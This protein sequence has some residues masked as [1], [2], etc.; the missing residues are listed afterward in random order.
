M[1]KINIEY[2][3][4]LHCRATHGPSGVS[5]ETDAP[6]DNQGRGESFSPTDLMATSLGACIATIMGIVAR[7]HDIDLR[8]M[9]VEVIKEMIQ[10]PVRRIG[11]LSV[12]FA[13]PRALPPDQRELLERAARTCPCCLSL[14]P[15]VAV[16]VSFNYP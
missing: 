14:H 8:G 9:K 5:I 15:D 16:A 11:K 1:V 10:Q 7:R 2:L 4:D 12:A 13:M 6:K 3:G